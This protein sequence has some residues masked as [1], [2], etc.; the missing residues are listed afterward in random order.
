MDTLSDNGRSTSTIEHVSAVLDHP[1]TKPALAV[2]LPMQ[3]LLVTM[4]P[5][6]IH[7]P[8]YPLAKRA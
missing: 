2:C 4:Q 5:S 8:I 7:H 3:L 6:S 1:A